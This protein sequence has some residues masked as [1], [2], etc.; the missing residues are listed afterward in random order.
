MSL[1]QFVVSEIYMGECNTILSA[2]TLYRH[3][4]IVLHSPIEM[5]LVWI[6]L[7]FHSVAKSESFPKQPIFDSSKLIDFADKNSKL[8]KNGRKVPQMGRK[9]CGKR[10]NC[11]F[12]ALSKRKIVSLT[13]FNLSSANAFDLVMSKFVVW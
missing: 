9:H 1:L 10:R 5:H 6:S 11:L 13:A 3:L 7:K 2:Y 8:V 4:R 12:S